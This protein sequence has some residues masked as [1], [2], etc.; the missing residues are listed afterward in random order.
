MDFIELLEIVREA[1]KEGLIYWNIDGY[2]KRTVPTVTGLGKLSPFTALIE[3]KHYVHIYAH[4]TRMFD[5]SAPQMPKLVFKFEVVDARSQEGAG[6]SS[7]AEED[8]FEEPKQFEVMFLYLVA[9]WGYTRQHQPS[10]L[11][12]LYGTSG[13]PFNF[14]PKDWETVDLLR[15][16][17]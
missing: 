4:W 10:V 9:L 16:H 1:T 6:L 8:F 2:N 15:F 7:R 11:E 12:V 14:I 3:G 13:V 5:L 17:Y